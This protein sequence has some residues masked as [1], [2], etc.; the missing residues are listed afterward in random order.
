MASDYGSL[1]P[2]FWLCRRASLL[3]SQVRPMELVDPPADGG[4]TGDGLKPRLSDDEQRSLYRGEL[5]VNEMG[6]K[7]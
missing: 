2:R 4:G 3:R 6:K 5:W 7:L 1:L